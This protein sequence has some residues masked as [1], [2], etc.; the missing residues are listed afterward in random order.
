MRDQLGARLPKFSMDERALVQ[1]SND[2]Y[3]MN[4]YTAD[5]V[6]ACKGVPADQDYIGNLEVHKTNQSGASIGPETQSAWL[7]PH[8]RGFRKL[9]RWISDRYDYPAIYVT[10]NG[11]SIK[12]ENDMPVE[13]ILQD[14]FR[15]D[16]FRGYIT[17]LAEAS[18]LDKVDVRGY[19]A[20]SLLE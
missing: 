15:A 7:R 19:M 9:L 5:F 17:A 2:A 18:A 8:P 16:Y 11:T 10:E 12:G 20:W 1:G 4:C 13:E 14:D 6:R 3:F